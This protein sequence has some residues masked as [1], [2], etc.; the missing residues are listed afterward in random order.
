MPNLI[1]TFCKIDNA[2]RQ[3]VVAEILRRRVLAAG[4]NVP[5]ETAAGDVVDRRALGIE[6]ILKRRD[7]LVDRRFATDQLLDVDAG[8]AEAVVVTFVQA[9]DDHSTRFAH[10][11]EGALNVL[12]LLHVEEAKA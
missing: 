4:D 8:M 11:I 5:A 12:D 1:R 10:L 6:P 7:D 3:F 2:R 9:D